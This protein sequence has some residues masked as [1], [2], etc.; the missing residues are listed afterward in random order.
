MSHPDDGELRALLDGELPP[1]EGPRVLG[2]LEACAECRA[3]RD[4]LRRAEATAGAALDALRPS[5]PDL[6]AARR[7]VLGRTGDQAGGPSRQDRSIERRSDEHDTGPGRDSRRRSPSS[8]SWSGQGSLARAAAVVL[9]LVGGA[10]AGLPGSPVREW[11]GDLWSSGA[12]A[13]PAATADAPTA[14]EET[15]GPGSREAEIRVDPAAG[16]V[17]VALTDAR[18]GTRVRILLV[19]DGSAGVVA[20]AAARF[21]SG[22]G[23]VEV[24]GAGG[25]VR[26]EIPRSAREA[27]VTANGRLLFRKEGATL[28]LPSADPDTAGAELLFRVPPEE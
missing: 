9:L 3:R 2:H 13:G 4:E 23:R 12:P 8:R 7:A 20:D 17:R 27:R 1:E 24:V 16:A 26:V 21:R 25:E 6:D 10:A 11:L 5:P 28:T 15:E 22:P 18:P 14:V 19:E